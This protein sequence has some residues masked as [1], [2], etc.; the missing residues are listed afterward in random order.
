ME[1]RFVKHTLKSIGHR[2]SSVIANV[3]RS[4]Q[5]ELSERHRQQWIGYQ[6]TLGKTLRHPFFNLN[7]S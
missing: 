6:E 7:N 3:L 2:L 1:N 4:T 5:E